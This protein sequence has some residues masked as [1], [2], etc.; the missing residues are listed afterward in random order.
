MRE[1]G[2]NRLTVMMLDGGD[3]TP[4]LSRLVMRLAARG[5]TMHYA[6]DPRFKDFDAMGAAGVGCH[7]I[8]IRHKLDFKA[9]KRIRALLK[10]HGVDILHTI[11]SRDAYA[12]IKARGKLP[13]RVVVRRGAYAPIS[14]LDP[15]DR[16]IY[17]R[18]G[19]D[20]VIAVSKDLA[21]NMASYGLA[22]D[23]I[24]QVY[25][26]IWSEELRPRERDLRAEYGVAR[27]ALL[28][29]YVG[30]DRRVKGFDVLVDA[31]NQLAA[32]GTPAH[33]L[34]A[35]EG[36]DTDRAYPANITLVGFVDG[37]EGFTPNLDAF[38]IPSRIDAL[39]RAV[40]EA[41]V[42]GTPVIGTAVGGIPEILD[43][44]K[45]GVLVPSEDATALADA[46][47]SA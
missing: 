37:V 27:D 43:D 36:Y 42:L 4:Y 9:R 24:R 10:E 41:T 30:N 38:V 32:R 28:L 34:V 23:R 2:Q 13:T 39:P 5:I 6:G 40:I 19:A 47:E 20:V 31:M 18:R 11:T 15:A 45:G 29:G 44:G 16:L 8:D 46:I 21:A 14:R 1:D 12:G 3:R 22:E 33:L 35:G 17:G 26:G 25:T 7:E